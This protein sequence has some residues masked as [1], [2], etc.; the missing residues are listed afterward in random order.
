MCGRYVLTQPGDALLEAGLPSSALEALPEEV[1]KPRYNIAPSQNVVA[2]RA[3]T[4]QQGFEPFVAAWGFERSRDRRR[5]INAR[6]ETIGERPAFRRAFENTRCLLP[7]TG[8][9]EWPRRPGRGRKPTFFHAADRSTLYMAGLWEGT[10]GRQLVCT[11]LTRAAVSPVD[12]LHDRMP[13]FLPRDS[14]S[15]WLQESTTVART[16]LETLFPPTLAGYRVGP[17][18]NL[19]TTEGPECLEPWTEQSEPARGENLRLF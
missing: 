2:F 12:E 1:L 10:A 9:F 11:I 14:H 17:R 5:L 18:V 16:L 15:A 13:V 8:F 7:A 19:A 4:C 3:L 6:H